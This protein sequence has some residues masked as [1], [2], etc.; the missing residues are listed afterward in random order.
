M[1]DKT[2]N[3]KNRGFASMDKAKQKEIASMGGK[4][5][6]SNRSHMANIGALG[7]QKS[8]E[9]RSKKAKEELDKTD[10]IDDK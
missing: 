7:G 4:K 5:V 3:T 1:S 2:N 6:S 9:V 10:L 8:G